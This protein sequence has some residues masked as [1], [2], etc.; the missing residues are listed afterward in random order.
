MRIGIIGLGRIGEFHARTLSALPVVE[1]LFVTDT[2]PGR[3]VDI[4]RMLGA[5]AVDDT[6]ALFACGL[7]GVVIAAATSAHPAL[8]AA[9]V[10]AELP[11]FC[12]KPVAGSA[13]EAAK[14]AR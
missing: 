6:A 10:D 13:A 14:I 2:A 5:H 7:D 3:A 1:T 8:L 12:E 9:C 11:V 4:A